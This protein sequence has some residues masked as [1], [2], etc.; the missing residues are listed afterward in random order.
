MVITAHDLGNTGSGGAQIDTDT[1][2]VQVVDPSSTELAITKTDGVTTAAAG[3][4]VP[5]VITASNAG[6]GV[7]TGVTVTDSFPAPLTWT[8]TC[9]FDGVNLAPL[10]SFFAY[11]PAFSGGVRVGR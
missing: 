10:A 11:D 4:S 9:V 8:W 6:P 5:Y 3:G 2:S 1:V 7:A